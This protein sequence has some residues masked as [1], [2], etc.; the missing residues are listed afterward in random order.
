[1][2]IKI[3]SYSLIYTHHVNSFQVILAACEFF[4]F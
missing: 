2:K 4:D 1:M 3:I